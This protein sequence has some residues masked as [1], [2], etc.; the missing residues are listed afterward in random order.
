MPLIIIN[1]RLNW[2][3]QWLVE[4]QPK[5]EESARCPGVLSVMI[6][7]L[8]TMNACWAY[9]TLLPKLV[10]NRQ[11]LLEIAGN[12]WKLLNIVRIFSKR[13]MLKVICRWTLVCATRSN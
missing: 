7:V 1:D 8:N 13:L 6:R 2:K 10:A 4:M 12:C 3:R 9:V 5:R 11:E